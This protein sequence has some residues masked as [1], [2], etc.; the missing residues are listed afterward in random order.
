MLCQH[1]MTCCLARSGQQNLMT[2]ETDIPK[3]IP[4]CWHICS[5]F[6]NLGVSQHGMMLTFWSCSVILVSW[7]M[8][9]KNFPTFIL[10]K[11]PRSKLF[12]GY[13]LLIFLCSTLIKTYKV[14][15]LNHFQN[16]KRQNECLLKTKS[17]KNKWKMYHTVIIQFQ[18]FRHNISHLSPKYW[19][20]LG[21]SHLVGLK[22][23]T[24]YLVILI[25]VLEMPWL[26]K[27]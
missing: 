4:A 8:V 20:M 3:I 27:R 13:L 6:V 16:W 12:D 9:I 19:I 22:S 18:S 26:L 15:T 5:H 21:V 11:F 25:T 2:W 1:N 7:G 23:F 17:E 14:M 10:L 24:E